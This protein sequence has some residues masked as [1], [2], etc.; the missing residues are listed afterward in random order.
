MPYIELLVFPPA[1]PEEAATL[2][3]G[4]TDA[5]A[6][7]MGKHRE[8][9]AVRIAGADTALWALGGEPASDRVACLDIKITAGTNRAEEKAALIGHLHGLLETTLGPLVEASYIMVHELPAGDWGYHG[10]TQAARSQG[11]K[12]IPCE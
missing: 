7:I 5:M 2:A 12:G 4:I 11:K 3:R 10:M 9:T 8:V 6:R 1:S